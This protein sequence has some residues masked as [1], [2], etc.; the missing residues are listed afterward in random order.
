MS[1]VGH[2]N[3]SLEVSGAILSLLIILFMTF[4]S[5]QKSHQDRLFIRIL[6][7]NALV[8]ICDATAWMFK[9]RLDAFSL[10]AVPVANFL[11]YSFGYLLL[12]TFTDYFV[13]FIS[14]KNRRITRK[15]V[16]VIYAVTAIAIL[17]VVL[18]QF[19]HMYYLIDEQN[20]YRRQNLFWVSQ[21][22]GLVGMVINASTLFRYRRNFEKKELAIFASYIALPIIAMSVQIFM[23]G[24]A[25]LY[26][27]TNIEVICIY[28]FIQAE[29]SRILS[30]KELELEKSRLALMLS[31]IKPHF[32]SNSLASISRLCDTN[33][34]AVKT[35]IKTF[36]RYL[37][38][39]IDSLTASELVPF[40]KELEHVE[41]Y[42]YL[43]KL[44]FDERLNIIYDIYVSDFFLPT[45]VLQPIVENAVKHGITKR[46]H[47]GTLI[48]KTQELPHCIQIIVTDDGVG[49]DTKTGP[50]DG[51]S[52]IGIENVR[53][54]LQ[55]QCGGKLNIESNVGKGTRVIIEIPKSAYM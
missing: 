45:L 11:V 13:S 38:K 54:R 43:E 9:T 22:F 49:F 10:F 6:I 31:Q 16:Y 17:G 12:A 23:Y 14:I 55:M 24:I 5:R 7:C 3:I 29:Q 48:I 19:N 27:A 50:N 46:K 28:V 47:G 40:H 51:I 33:P 1:T 35:S 42:L 44:R 20:I 30:E 32:I 53:S 4:S 34:E 25:L 26:I 2:I 18:S 15:T 21:I 39:N 41:N 8:L 52:H 37:S 36:S